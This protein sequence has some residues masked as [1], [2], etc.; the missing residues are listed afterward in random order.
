M[1]TKARSL[2]EEDFLSLLEITDI[3]TLVGKVFD[4]YPVGC[5]NPGKIEYS[6]LDELCEKL[7][8]G[9]GDRAENI[10]AVISIVRCASTGAPD[11]C[12]IVEKLK[13]EISSDLSSD[14]TAAELAEKA[15]ISLY[16]MLHIFKKEVGRT[17]TEYRNMCR[18]EKAKNELVNSDKNVTSIALECGFANSSYFAETFKQSTRVTPLEYRSY[19]LEYA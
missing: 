16:Y 19:T 5:I 12:P 14:I 6:K 15:G 11:P 3:D 1:M 9:D 8:S 7:K 2:T 17:I 4:Y 13:S 10:R 18:L